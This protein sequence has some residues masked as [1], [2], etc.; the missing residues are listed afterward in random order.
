MGAPQS[1]HLYH[2][3]STYQSL[4]PYNIHSGRVC[5]FAFRVQHSWHDL[6]SPGWWRICDRCRRYICESSP[7]PETPEKARPPPEKRRRRHD[8]VIVRYV[9]SSIICLSVSV[10]NCLTLH[11]RGTDDVRQVRLSAALPMSVSPACVIPPTHF[12]VFVLHL[13]FSISRLTLQSVCLCP[14]LYIPPR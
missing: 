14:I 6:H 3:L 2:L 7:E 13:P 5:L 8:A 12:P 4:A 1:P 11:I 9:A 10:F